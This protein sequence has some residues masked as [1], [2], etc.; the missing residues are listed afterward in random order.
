MGFKRGDLAFI[1]T[2]GEQVTVLTPAES[3]SESAVVQVRRPVAGQNGIDHIVNEFFLFELESLDEQRKRFLA[4]RQDI[5][6][7][8]A[9]KGPTPEAKNFLA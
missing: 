6:E 9:P 5:Y 8:F 4:E 1:R 2:T 3:L 7:K